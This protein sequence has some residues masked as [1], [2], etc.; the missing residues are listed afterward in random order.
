MGRTGNFNE[1]KTLYGNYGTIFIDDSQVTEASGIQAKLKINKV[2]VPMCG[3]LS[4]KYKIVGWDGSGTLTLNKTNSRIMLML[5]ADLKTGKETPFTII[6]KM[7]DPGN[8]GTER[9]KLINCKVDEVTLADW[10]A[11]KLGAESVPFTFEDFELLD[12]IS[13]DNV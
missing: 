12:S 13:P 6:S 4:K 7:S 9:V 8:G 10:S 3:T 11:G 2:E 5:V 1:E